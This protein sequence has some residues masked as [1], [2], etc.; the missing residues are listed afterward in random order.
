[1]TRDI[2]SDTLSEITTV[3]S[4]D[5][6]NTDITADYSGDG[7]IDRT[8]DIDRGADGGFTSTTQQYGAGYDLQQV[9]TQTVSADGRSSVQTLDIDGDGFVDQR[10]DAV[11]DLSGNTTTIYEDVQINGVV[12]TRVTATEAANGMRTSYAFDVDGDGTTD[13][14]RTTDIYYNDNGDMVTSFSETYGSGT[15]GYQESTTTSANGLV[16]ITAFDVDGD[17]EI[18][19]SSISVTTLHG[20]GARDTLTETLYADGELHSSVAELVSADGRTTTREMDYD[21]N[22]IADK[23]SVLEIAADGSSVETVASYNVAGIHNNTFITSTSA[24]GLTTT[25]MRQ[26][27]VQTTTRSVLDNGSYDWDN[28]VTG[29]GHRSTSHEID[30]LGV[31]TWSLTQTTGTVTEQFEVRLDASA[32]DRLLDEAASIYDTVLDRGLDSGESEALIQWVDDGQLDKAALIDHLIGSGE[33]ATRYGTQ[34]DAEFVTQAYMNAFGRSPSMVELAQTLSVLDAGLSTRAELTLE[35]NDS[36]EHSVVGNGHM[37]TNNFDVIMNPAVF[38]RSLDRAYV[39]S[40]ITNIVDVVYDRDPTEQELTYLSELL[41]EGDKQ[42]DDIAAI[43]MG[44]EGDLT[45]VS[46]TTLHGL[47]G[48]AL[49]QQAFLNALGR[50]ATADELSVWTGHLS[51]ANLSAAQLVASLAQSAEHLEHGNAHLAPPSVGPALQVGTDDAQKLDG[52]DG[53]DHIMGFAGNDTLRGRNGSDIL[54]GGLDNDRL[55]G[56][57]GSDTYL[58][59][60]GDGNDT[61]HDGFNSWIETDTLVLENVTSDDVSFTRTNGSSQLVIEVLSTGELIKVDHQYSNSNPGRG[62]ERVEFDGG[63][64]W[65]LK[66]ILAAV[67]VSG[68]TGNNTLDGTNYDDRLF[69]LVGNDQIIADAGDDTLV[70]GTGVDVLRG[71]DGSDTYL[72]QRGDGD[73]YITENSPH[74][75]DGGDDVDTLHFLDVGSQDVRLERLGSSTDARNDLWIVI[76]TP[77]GGGRIG[78]WDQFDAAG[79]GLERIEFSDGE[80]WDLQ[81]II[82]QT[83]MNGTSSG[84]TIHGLNSTDDSIRGLEGNDTLHGYDGDDTLVGNQGADELHGGIGSDTYVWSR[85][86]GNDTVMDKNANLIDQDILVFEDVNSTDVV[87]KRSSTGSAEARDNLTI[88]IQ[89]GA[90]VEEVLVAD[91]FWLNDGEG[92]ELISFADGITWTVEDILSRTWMTGTDGVET[93]YGQAGDDNIRGLAGDDTIYSGYGDDVVEGGM[94]NDTVR[95]TTGNDT[96]LWSLGHGNDLI[97]DTGAATEV[98]TLRLTDVNSDNADLTKVGDDL[99]VTI[100][101]TGETITVRDRFDVGTSGTGDGIEFITFADGVNVEVL[102]G[103]L[104]ETITTGTE[105]ANTLVGWGLEDTIYGLGGN[106]VLEGEGGDDTLIGGAGVDILRGGA[107]NDTY[108]WSAGDG[109]DSIRDN[110]SNT[111]EIDRLILTDI[112]SGD[113]ELKRQEGSAHVEITILSTGEMIEVHNRY[114]NSND[115]RGIEEIHFGDG[116]VWSLDEIRDATIVE[117]GIGGTVVKGTSFADNLYGLDGADTIEGF[118]GDDT[119]VGGVGSDRLEGGIGN[120]TYIWERGAGNDKIDDR[121]ANTGDTDT[122]VLNGVLSSDVE[123]TRQF[124]TDTNIRDNLFVTISGGAAVELIEIFDQFDL[125]DGEGIE[126]IRFGDGETWT[127]QDILDQTTIE[128][129][130]QDDTMYGQGGRDNIYGRDGNDTITGK[131]GDDDLFGEGGDDTLNGDGGNDLLDGGDGNDTLNGGDGD[132]ALVGG[133]GDDVL[134][135]GLGAN[136]FDGGS[137]ID[138][139]D[140]SFSNADNT[141]DLLNGQVNWPS[142]GTI[143]TIVNVENVIGT[144]GDNIIIG[145]TGDNRFEG[146]GGDDTL[147]G[148]A[149]NDHLIGGDGDDILN[150]GAGDDTIS[151]GIGVDIF[152]GGAGMDTVDFSYSSGDV[153][154]DLVTEIADWSGHPDEDVIS[155]ENVIGSGGSNTIT[156]TDE[157]N[158]LDGGSGNDTLYGGDGDDVILGGLGTDYHDGGDGIDTVDFSHSSSAVDI[159]LVAGVAN[160]SSG[161]TEVTIAFENVIG[162]DGANTITGTDGNNALDGQAGNDTLIG[163]SGDDTLTG[164]SGADTFVFNLGDGQDQITDFEDGTDMM[165]FSTSGLSFADLTITTTGTSTFIDYDNGQQIELLNTSGLIDQDDFVF[166]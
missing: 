61:I 127:L 155:F 16:T 97:I 139:A 138:T 83:W 73:D 30:A 95:S 6:L 162:S 142:N 67:T 134:Y 28:G 136:S 8:V 74:T 96:F 133:S 23:T 10:V 29:S 70:G 49:V 110:E 148:G 119:L 82:D 166:V 21:G 121:N 45:G 164:G 77:Q 151:G 93:I 59:A 86:D 101:S 109:N 106:D 132:D 131:T 41:L 150:G 130:A 80:V 125:D 53:Q 165:D 63:T 31:E 14:T 144:G 12:S 17:D 114:S 69:G 108:Q 57:A 161:T 66:D 60:K 105:A 58:W 92:V 42:P 90:E 104:A 107:G 156:G 3:T 52:G 36:V 158:I 24:D 44:V 117:D 35:I 147:D 79:E 123:L 112:S 72:W 33:Y 116:V 54:D 122:L 126:A 81:D 37:L 140:F 32:K 38:E 103:A 78:V 137:G 124:T 47:S 154:V 76:E 46:T 11:V 98:D 68:G 43:L 115:G 99:I 128:G 26:G 157:N 7:S 9:A 129:T 102:G 88:E 5:G 55:E 18:D 48:E 56:G 65:T 143:E 40:V 22:G 91:Q 153:D 1:M 145:D 75:E 113:V 25:V 62:I 120:D 71:G 51:A 2:T 135:G 146:R 152:D 34:S 20:S 149:G 141:I 27:N 159:D 19:G 89:G 111:S 160:W 15:L 87:L 4:G 84:N 118:A 50:E 94:G 13:L 100:I 85:G 64:V 163:G 39:E